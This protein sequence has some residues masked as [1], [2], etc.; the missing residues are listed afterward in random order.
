MPHRSAFG[1]SCCRRL[2]L[3]ARAGTLGAE[4]QAHAFSRRLLRFGVLQPLP[5]K[6]GEFVHHVVNPFAVH[7][8]ELVE[9]V[10]QRDLDL[11][12]VL[13][14]K[15]L[16]EELDQIVCQQADELV[17]VGGLNNFEERL[18]VGAEV[19]AGR[20][21]PSSATELSRVSPRTWTVSASASALVWAS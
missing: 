7:G 8:A 20:G 17:R 14:L 9:D 15:Q 16:A 3:S 4:E 19:V 5:Q 21:G 12:E 11:G 13:L 6:L 18:E 2:T 1:P 10:G